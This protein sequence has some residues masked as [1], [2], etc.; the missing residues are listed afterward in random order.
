MI[1]GLK[2]V[3]DG[4]LRHET[5][6]DVR[7]EKVAA[8]TALARAGAATPAMLGQISITPKEM[9]T[10]SVADYLM[11]LDKV[12]GRRQRHRAQGSGGGRD[13]LAHRL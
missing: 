7:L 3:L 13:P 5:Y 8:F 9:P 6:G 1:E 12:P 10:A 11:A 4:R 2:A